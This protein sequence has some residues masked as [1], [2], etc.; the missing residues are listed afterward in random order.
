MEYIKTQLVCLLIVIYI[1]YDYYRENKKVERQ[2]KVTRF[3]HLLALAIMM[4]C[5]DALTAYSVN[6]LDIVPNA[7][8]L[9]LHA[10]FL[11]SIDA[12]IF[13]M[14]QYMLGMTEGLPKEKNKRFL[15]TLPFWI[16]VAVVV[17]NINHLEFVQGKFTNYSMGVSAYTCFALVA[18]YSVWAIVIF[19]KR[20]NYIDRS[21]RASIILCLTITM[22]VTVMQMLIPEALLTSVVCAIVILGIYLN[23]EN[24]DIRESALYEHEMIMGFATLVEKRDDNTGGHIRRTSKYAELLAKELRRKGCYKKILTKDFIDNL[25][26]AAPMHDIGKISVPDAI[27]QKPGKL[28][29]EEFSVMKLHAKDGGRIIKETLCKVDDDDYKTMAYNV[30]TYHHE[31]WNGRGYPEGMKEHEIPLEA[32]IMAIADVFDAVSEKR[33]YRDALPLEECFQIIKEG[34]GRDFEPMLVDAFL[35]IRDQIEDTHDKL[36][37]A[38]IQCSQTL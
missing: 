32:R 31:K 22:L 18:F 16:C 1:G 28:T 24:P 14:F 3:D 8:N 4:L 6:R 20:W 34:S 19:V 9:I 36:S 27:L 29:D 38:K 7:L 37:D 12:F 25:K 35:E 17:L 21:K 13:G 5:F 33:C 15:M 2:H 30:A 10:F 26:M 11:T 23:L